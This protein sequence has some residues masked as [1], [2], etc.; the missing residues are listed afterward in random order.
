MIFHDNLTLIVYRPSLSHVKV[1]RSRN[2][3]AGTTVEQKDVQSSDLVVCDMLSI[4]LM[5]NK[6]L[7]YLLCSQAVCQ[8]DRRWDLCLLLMKAAIATAAD[9]GQQRWRRVN[10]IC[11]HALTEGGAKFD[12][13]NWRWRRCVARRLQQRPRRH[14][15]Q[16]ERSVQWNYLPRLSLPHSPS[17]CATPWCVF[18]CDI[19]LHLDGGREPWHTATGR[20]TSQ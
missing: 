14:R 18:A 19:S 4:F 8:W 6:A 10:H 3:P 17:R 12:V 20:N 11:S 7:T 2:R 1:K 9:A 16:A 13:V 5:N 15:Q